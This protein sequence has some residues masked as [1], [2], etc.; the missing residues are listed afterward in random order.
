MTK[1]QEAL[2]QQM[3]S[4]QTKLEDISNRLNQVEQGKNWHW[5]RMLFDWPRHP[6]FPLTSTNLAD[7]LYYY[8]QSMRRSVGTYYIIFA[9]LYIR[10]GLAL[11]FQVEGAIRIP[12]IWL[13]ILVSLLYLGIGF[14]N[15]ACI[16][17]PFERL[18]RH[19]VAPTV[20]AAFLMMAMSVF[21]DAFHQQWILMVLA[22]LFWMVTILIHLAFG[23]SIHGRIGL[24]DFTVRLA[25]AS[26]QNHQE[27]QEMPPETGG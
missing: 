10:T 19:L 26:R 5:P 9:A 25:D 16:L 27:C 1:T 21:N 20:G 7:I 11:L 3:E 24:R 6:V 13:H 12:V 23:S 4:I 22:A 8:E 2:I 17:A 15:I 18:Q 14:T